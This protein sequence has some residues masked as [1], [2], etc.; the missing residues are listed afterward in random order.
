MHFVQVFVFW[1][2][3]YVLRNA[4]F[5]ICS[6]IFGNNGDGIVVKRLNSDE[7][8]STDSD[9]E[10]IASS[11]GRSKVDAPVAKVPR[12]SDWHKPTDFL[13]DVCCYALEGT[14]H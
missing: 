2:C 11:S 13:T 3:H 8:L 6:S 10:S 9:E 7:E 5:V 1:L 12:T 14:T 4:I